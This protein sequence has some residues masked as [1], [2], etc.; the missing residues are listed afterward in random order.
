MFKIL[1]KLRYPGYGLPV[2][3]TP[4]CLQIFADVSIFTRNFYPFLRG[5]P[6]STRK[7]QTGTGAFCLLFVGRLSSKILQH[8]N[9]IDDANR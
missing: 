3:V 5:K 9:Q 8:L 2:R 6:W 1:E 7:L 4:F